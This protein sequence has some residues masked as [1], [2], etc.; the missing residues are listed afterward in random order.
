M[1]CCVTILENG[2]EVYPKDVN[3]IIEEMLNSLKKYGL[4]VPYIKLVLDQVQKEVE[5]RAIF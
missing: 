3:P 1:L 4:T 5:R 2:Q